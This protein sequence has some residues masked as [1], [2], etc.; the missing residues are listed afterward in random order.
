MSEGSDR[1]AGRRLEPAAPGARVT[2]LELFYDL[3]FVFAFLNVTGVTAEFLGPSALLKTLL[4]L[5]LLWFGWTSFA[6]L[7]NVIRADQGVMPLFGFATMAIIFVAVVTLPEAFA[8]EPSGLPGDLVFASCYFLVRALQVLAFW[9]AVRG[10]RELQRRWRALAVPVLI[11]VTL[12]IVA[13]LVPQRLFHGTAEFAGRAGLWVLAIGIEY[14]AS[15][16]VRTKDT[17]IPLVSA[18]HWAERHAQI[19]L[20]AF[21]ESVISLGTGPKLRSGLP[22]TWSVIT[23]SVL[24]IAV[25]AALW[26]AYFD[27]LA[28][29]AERALHQSRG[30][31]RIALARDAYTYLH[32]PMIAG[33][34]LFSTGLN[35]VLTN[36]A[37][38]VVPS[39]RDSLG[40]IDLYVLYGGV[41]LYLLAL[42]GFQ[43]R[44]VGRVDGFQLAAMLLLAALIPVADRLSA[45]GSLALLV[46]VAVGLVIVMSV[47]ARQPRAK[48]RREKLEEQR[49]L[50]A[51]ETEWR[52]RHLRRDR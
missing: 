36:I 45:F 38:P 12:L 32:L 46:L 27:S 25:I 2:P 51:E 48:L 15:A 21:G 23:A 33:I 7:G 50:E 43:F 5:P 28:I 34:I 8:D 26:F 37:D 6:A 13:A 3:V 9:Y 49:A 11:S 29:A 24:G 20:I 47:W 17:G 30:A 10:D 19:I 14:G 22:L 35:R 41:I 39:T 40:G 31:A 1:P 18:G 52:R 16:L 44:T 42:L 4:V